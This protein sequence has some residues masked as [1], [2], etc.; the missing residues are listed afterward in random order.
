M[1]RKHF[2]AVGPSLIVAAGIIGSTFIAVVAADWQWLV[3]AAPAVLALAFVGADLLA[4]RMGGCEARP[5]WPVLLLGATIILASQ[6]VAL[7]DPAMM[8]MLL[9]VIA[10]PLWVTLMLRTDG[11]GRAC[12][13][14][15]SAR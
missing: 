4:A 3:M 15:R 9:P 8:K 5:S 7:R 11:G 6:L 2:T 1:N 13:G 14:F 10:G 12:C